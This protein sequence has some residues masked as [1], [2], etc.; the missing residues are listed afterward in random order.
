M[1][2]NGSERALRPIASSRKARL[3]CGSDE[4]AQSAAELMSLIASARLHTL[5]PEQ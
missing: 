2:H 5:S 4:H 3:F 1:T